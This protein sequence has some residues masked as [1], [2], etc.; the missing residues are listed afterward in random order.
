M[1]EG[2]GGA[3]LLDPH[4]MG[5][6][7][8]GWVR[9]QMPGADD[10]R[11]DGLD[12][13]AFGHSAEMLTLTLAWRAEGAEHR[14]DVVVRL[15]PPPPGLLEPYDMARQFRILRALEGTA[16]R[17]P[18]AL[19]LE[20]TGDV[21]GRA[22][23]VMERLD[24]DVYE[25]AVPEELEHAP[26][27]VRRMCVS[28]VDQIAAIHAVDLRATGLDGL[29]DGS[30]ALSREL[31]HWAGEVERV[32]RGL[33]PQ[34]G[35]LHDELRRRLPEQCP[36][37]TLVH[38][39][40]KPGNF[41][42]VGDDVSAVFDWEMAAVGDPLAD[43]AWT[44]V[45][46]EL[47]SPF[48][49]RPGALTTDELVARYEALTGIAVP[50]RAWYRA[51]QGFKLNVILLL[52]SMLFDRGATDDLRLGMMGSA[53]PYLTSRA[54]GEL[55]IDEAIDPGPVAPRDERIRAVREQVRSGG[56]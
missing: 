49:T 45:T 1:A 38:G 28:M 21:L 25:T 48:T 56:H 41:A 39:D 12:R 44:E 20:P 16:V 33:L 32:R 30:D 42:F 52:G 2:A 55:G 6:Q 4:E 24:G 8:A 31:D 53:I 47:G 50:H 26:A 9:A 7:L 46:W 40:T 19:W 14:R 36:T 43:V 18:R 23:Y 37:V 29:G 22:F 51:F 17:S 3:P 54:L 11:V 15:R 5:E 13:V 27:R 35:R 34:L 10:L